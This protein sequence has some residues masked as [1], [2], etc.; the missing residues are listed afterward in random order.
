M[1]DSS[2]QCFYSC[3]LKTYPHHMKGDMPE[4]GN[5]LQHELSAAFW[6]QTWRQK[7]IPDMALG[8]PSIDYSVP[9]LAPF[10]DA[11]AGVKKLPEVPAVSDYHTLA[12]HTSYPPAYCDWA[13]QA[14]SLSIEGSNAEV[15]QLITGIEFV[16]FLT[17]CL[18]LKSCLAFV[19]QSIAQLRLLSLQ[20]AIKCILLPRPSL[21]NKGTPWN[22]PDTKTLP[23]LQSQEYRVQLFFLQ[24]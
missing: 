16:T 18:A 13:W 17:P 22:R 5:R 1:K 4:Y 7:T 20:L 2:P 3:M 9:C 6:R 10:F 11:M 19:L 15:G 14:R 21:S 12:C 24:L 8:F 23:N